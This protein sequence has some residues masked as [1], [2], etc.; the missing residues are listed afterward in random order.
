MF[1]QSLTPI[2]GALLPSFVVAAL[3]ILTVLV[4]LGVLRRPAWQAS[5]TGLLVGL[6]V[7]IGPWRFPVGLA[8]DAVASGAAFATWP[9]MWIV[10]NALLLYNISIKSGRFDA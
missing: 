5:L 9:L 7:A 10:F 2:S 3:P 8:L 1:P 6:I 4:M